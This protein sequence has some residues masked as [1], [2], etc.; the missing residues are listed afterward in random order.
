MGGTTLPGLL[1]S[2]PYSLG[3]QREEPS[4]RGYCYRAVYDKGMYVSAARVLLA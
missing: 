1:L 4:P 2:V 3:K